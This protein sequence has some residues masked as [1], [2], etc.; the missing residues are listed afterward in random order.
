MMTRDSIQ[1]RLE[2]INDL[3]VEQAFI[4]ELAETMTV[5]EAQRELDEQ[6]AENRIQNERCE[7]DGRTCH[8]SM[9]PAQG[10]RRVMYC[11]ALRRT[12]AVQTA[13]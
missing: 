5:E 2:T 13:R 11:A 8:S 4:S 1:A 12:K 10:V 9:T 6:H 3:S 7:R